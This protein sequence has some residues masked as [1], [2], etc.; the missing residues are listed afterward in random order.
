[1]L[2]VECHVLLIMRPVL[3]VQ[4]HPLPA[5][6]PQVP[7]ASPMEVSPVILQIGEVVVVLFIQDFGVDGKGFES[8]TLQSQDQVKSAFYDKKRSLLILKRC[9]DLVL[10]FDKVLLAI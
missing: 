1:M 7:P 5:I 6:G 8:A 2:N 9:V 4:S 3:N 10:W